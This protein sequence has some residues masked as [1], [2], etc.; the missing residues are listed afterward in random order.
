MLTVSFLVPFSVFLLGVSF[1]NLAHQMIG[2]LMMMVVLMAS[3]T[4]PKPGSSNSGKPV[5]TRKQITTLSLLLLFNL[6]ILI[7]VLVMNFNAN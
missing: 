4:P 2:L 6:M 1:E 5:R 3:Y 7:A